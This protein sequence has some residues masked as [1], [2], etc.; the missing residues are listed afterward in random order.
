MTKRAVMLAVGLAMM[1]GSAWAEGL[2][3]SGLPKPRPAALVAMPEAV[4]STS[5]LAPEKRPLPRPAASAPPAVVVNVAAPAKRPQPRPADLAARFAALAAPEPVLA[6]VQEVAMVVPRVAVKRP[7]PRPSDLVTEPQVKRKGWGIF[8][9]A[10]VRT[11]P[12]K[13]AVLPKKG[14]VCGDTS[15]RGKE[16]AQITSR[17]RG[18]GVEAPVEVTEIAGVSLS[19]SATISCETAAAA[20]RWIERGIQ[21]AFDDQVAKLQIAG[22][23][24]C[25]PRNGIRGN[26]VSEHGRG[27]AL[28]VAAFVLKDGTTL[29][30]ARNY[31]KSASIKAAHKAACGPFGTTLGPGSDGHHEDHLHV[32]IV[33]YRNGT[34]CR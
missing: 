11:V 18:C 9:A 34:Y 13:A 33:S 27:R 10:A 23:Y 32:D 28:D 6:N 21:P 29:T 19:P 25:R 15:I 31:R 20:K 1:A 5:N 8:K 26:K 3:K 16:L 17:V 14:S 2:G 4:V 30:V 7:L 22:S 12:G 24:V